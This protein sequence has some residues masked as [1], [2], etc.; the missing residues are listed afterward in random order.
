M[1]L[2]GLVTVPIVLF[3]RV[4]EAPKRN[5]L[6]PLVVCC[7]ALYIIYTVIVHSGP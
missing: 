5:S 2:R 6:A 1:V 7:I 4:I 3:R